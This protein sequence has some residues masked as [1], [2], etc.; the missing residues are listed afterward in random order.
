[1]EEVT[2]GGAMTAEQTQKRP[3]TAKSR[4]TERFRTLL[5]QSLGTLRSACLDDEQI[6]QI[7]WPSLQNGERR[8][9]YRIAISSES[10]DEK[11][12]AAVAHAMKDEAA[13]SSKKA[14]KAKELPTDAS[15][16]ALTPQSHR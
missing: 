3:R 5:G 16:K 2:A 6:A 4:R 14:D 7:V 15:K 13:S 8:H 10:E 9:A 1:M 11:A 12:L